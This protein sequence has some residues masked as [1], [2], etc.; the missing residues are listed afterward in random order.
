MV[1]QPD[2]RLRSLAVVALLVGL[3]VGCDSSDLGR[4]VQVEGIT[5][6]AIIRLE[7]NFAVAAR[8]RGRQ[9]DLVSFQQ[10]EGGRWTA[11]VIGSSLTDSDD[12]GSL[13]GHTGEEWNSYFFGSAADYVSHVEVARSDAIGGRVV[14]G[15][16]VVAIRAED[17][18]PD[19]AW[20]FIDA[21]GAMTSSGTGPFPPVE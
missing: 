8:R 14:D 21:S 7:D 16:W 19:L 3:L 12:S 18:R 20:R 6:A 15:A 5:P 2:N 17:V 11:Q 10:T 4:A 9:V 1:H 13:I